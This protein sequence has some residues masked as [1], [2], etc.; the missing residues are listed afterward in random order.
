MNYE[1]CIKPS[2]SLLFCDRAY[3][4]AIVAEAVVPRHVLNTMAEVE[5]VRTAVEAAVVR[6]RTPIFA[7][8]DPT[9][10]R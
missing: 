9:D 7:T 2:A 4:Q 1:L 8:A 6:R 10:E 3:R 5:A